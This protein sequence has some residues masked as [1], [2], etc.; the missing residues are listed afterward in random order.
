MVEGRVDAPGRKLVRRG[1][2]R[3]NRFI[4]ESGCAEITEAQR[5]NRY[6]RFNLFL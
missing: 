5:D 4:E 6:N 3:F 1:R 2:D